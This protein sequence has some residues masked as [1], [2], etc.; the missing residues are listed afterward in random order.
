MFKNISE[1][2]NIELIELNNPILNDKKKKIKKIILCSIGSILYSITLIMSTYG[3]TD[4]FKIKDI[5]C[6]CN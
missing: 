4:S 1:L 2:N 3:I 6:T 5:N